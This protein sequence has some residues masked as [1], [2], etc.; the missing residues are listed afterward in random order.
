MV[1]EKQDE[2]L[3]NAQVSCAMELR[4]KGIS[5]SSS[6]ISFQLSLPRMCL[7]ALGIEHPLDMTVQRSHD[8]PSHACLSEQLCVEKAIGRQPS[9]DAGAVDPGPAKPVAELHARGLILC[10]PTTRRGLIHQ[11]DIAQV[12]NRTAS[13][14]AGAL[15]IPVGEDETPWQ[16]VF[17]RSLAAGLRKMAGEFPSRRGHSHDQRCRLPGC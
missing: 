12:H 13:R 4:G 14:A 2:V 16:L 8:E 9:C 17:L 3:S 5:P 10:R 15:R 1:A 6:L 11:C 7:F